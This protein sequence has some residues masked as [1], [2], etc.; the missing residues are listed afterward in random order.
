M[1]VTFY[2]RAM[3]LAMIGVG[4]LGSAILEGVLAKGILRAADIGI[5]EHDHKRAAALVEQFGVTALELG[6]ISQAERALI[7]VKPG[8]FAQLALE[9]AHPKMGYI[10][11][12]AGIST[13]TLARK[14]GT[15]RVV[16]VMPNLGALVGKSATAIT[17]PEE[18]LESG[19]Y[20]FGKLLFAG[21]GDVY[22]LPE[23]LFNVFTGLS[24]SGPAYAAVFAEAL[25]DGGV[26]MGLPRDLAL[27]LAAKTLITTG[28]LLLTRPN[29]AT[30]KDEVSSPGGT[31]IAGLTEMERYTF[32]IALIEAVS[33]ATR[34]GEELGKD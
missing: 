5:L 24:G 32:R 23:H 31:T 16:R 17:A 28:E 3:K 7:A 20:D 25:A 19:D 8:Q 12:M 14:L 6:E 2:T 27:E 33:A 22:D 18:A 11:T 1:R 21:V 34:R 9:L 30:L 26:R 13:S 10:S 15:N 29:P 4:K